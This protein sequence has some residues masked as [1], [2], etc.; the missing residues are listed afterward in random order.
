MAPKYGHVVHASTFCLFEKMLVHLSI[1]SPTTPLPGQGGDLV[2]GLIKRAI[3]RG[4]EFDR[5]CG[6]SVYLNVEN[7]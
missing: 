2:V 4:G 6:L 3:P 7:Y 5:A 1:N